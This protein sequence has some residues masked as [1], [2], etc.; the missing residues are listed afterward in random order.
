MTEDGDEESFAELFAASEAKEKAH[1]RV[2][3]GDSVRGRI[4]SIGSSAAFVDIGAR[5]EALIDLAELVDPATGERQVAVGDEIEAHVTDDGR[6]SGTIVLRRTMGRGA[7]TAELE[8][9]HAHGIAVEGLVTG[10]NKGGFEVQIGGLRAFCPASQ[11]DVRRGDPESYVG[12][13]F[14]F[15]ITKLEGHGRN[16]V[17]SRR[18]VLE[19][20]AAELAAVTRARLQVGAVVSGTVVS[21]RDFG[22]FV[23]LGGIEGLIHVSELGYAR[24]QHPSEV[25]EVGQRVEAQVVKIEPGADGRRERVGLSLRA[26]AADPWRDV[27][28]R[29]PV[30]AEVPGVVQRVE[31]FGAFVQLAPGVEG[32]VHVSQMALDRRIAHARQA[33]TVGQEVA[34]TVLAIDP[35]KRRISLSMSARA[36][37]DRDAERAA[38]LAETA[39][40]VAQSNQEGRSLGTLADLLR[41]SKERKR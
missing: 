5:L 26:L 30:G 41:S 3:A 34:V 28:E 15:K 8:Q 39:E 2:A 31:Q 7:R 6:S 10:Q 13:R 24:P 4:V 40:L 36:R 11:I 33:A 25:L 29:F 37:Q 16:V 32:L 14:R 22:A 23:D 21:L 9:A 20:E 19:E 18:D 1:R 12:Q 38:D 17:V 35:E 27:P